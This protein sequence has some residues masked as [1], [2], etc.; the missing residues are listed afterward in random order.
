MELE[1]IIFLN[2]NPL[3][4]NEIYFNMIQKENL[5][6]LYHRKGYKNAPFVKENC[7]AKGRYYTYNQGVI[8]A[9]LADLTKL[10]RD[11]KYINQADKIALAAI[12]NMSTPEGILS[13][14]PKKEEGADGV[15]FKGIFM[16]HLAYLYLHSKNEEM[17]KYILKNAE[18]IQV[19]ATKENTYLIGSQWEGPFDKAD[20]GRQSSAIDALVSN[21]EISQLK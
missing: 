12:N 11:K 9:A 3:I 7:E 4:L 8:L 5:I 1:K 20:A 15:Q 17:K 16:R 21:L 13:S 19:S 10:T 2:A 6:E 14:H 18:S